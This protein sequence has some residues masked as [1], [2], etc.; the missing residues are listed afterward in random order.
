MWLC[1]YA[2]VSTSTS[3]KRTEGSS[4]WPLA[5]SASTRT[6][7]AYPGTVTGVSCSGVG[8]AGAAGTPRVRKA[9]VAG[10]D[11]RTSPAGDT[12]RASLPLPVGSVEPAEGRQPV[13]AGGM[14]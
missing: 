5:H 1:S 11:Q 10:D 8:G 3:T 2:V 14:L 7:L 12:R 9:V 13:T 4:R 6:S